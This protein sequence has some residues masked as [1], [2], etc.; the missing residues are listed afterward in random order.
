MCVRV[1][2]RG[3]DKQGELLRGLFD[4]ERISPYFMVPL[5]V[6]RTSGLIQFQAISQHVCPPKH[7]QG[8]LRVSVR[9]LTRARAPFIPVDFSLTPSIGSDF[10]KMCTLSRLFVRHIELT[11]TL[12]NFTAFSA[13]ETSN[14]KSISRIV[15]MA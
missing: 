14:I 13:K 2:D 9:V 3:R 15:H 10:L 7:L 1:S 12:Q 4:F 6:L 8:A 11:Q 5:F